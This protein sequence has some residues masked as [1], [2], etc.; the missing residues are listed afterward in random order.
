MSNTLSLQDQKDLAKRYAPIMWLHEEEAF[1]PEDCRRIS[2]ISNLY[3]KEKLAK[4]KRFNLGDILAI[5]GRNSQDYQFRIEGIEIPDYSK[6]SPTSKSPNTIIKE[7]REKLGYKIED[8]SQP[9]SPFPKYYARASEQ[10]LMPQGDEPF[11]K[12]FGVRLPDIFGD[13]FLV[14]YFFYFIFNDAWNLHQSDWDSKIEIW[15]NRNAGNQRIFMV[16]HFHHSQSVTEIIDSANITL[17]TWISG[18][19]NPKNTEVANA[20]SIDG[21]HPR[22]H[23]FVFIAQG[24][25][26]GYP[27]PGFTVFGFNIPH[28]PG[29]PVTV[30][31]LI[32][33]TDERQIGTQCIIPEDIE[34]NVIVDKL[35]ESNLKTDRLKF[36]SWKEPEIISDQPWIKYKGKWGQNTRYQGWDGPSD[37][38]FTQK[39]GPANFK[40][41]L[42]H[43][44]KGNTLLGGVHRLN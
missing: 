1:F 41:A 44:F 31:D 17:S 43:N 42:Q 34:Q 30:D 8:S 28:I 25:H 2:R 21:W 35:K 3:K 18:W 4:Q 9:N 12:Y 14:E 11:S 13:F 26:G 38:P 36:A 10:R 29:I 7:V 27:T 19:E 22:R 40:N 5:T 32:T 15:V 33:N 24:A 6:S 16:N 37:P 20:Y 39:P 23:P